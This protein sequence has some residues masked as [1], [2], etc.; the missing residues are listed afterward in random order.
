MGIERPRVALLSNGEE[1]TKGTP[2]LLE[3]HRQ[4]AERPV[5]GVEFVG[6]VE[7]TTLTEG[8]ADVVVADG[9]TGN[10]ALKLMEGVSST[11]FGAVRRAAESSVRGRAGGLLLR[12]ALRGLRDELDPE[13]AG[14]AYILGLR[15]VGVVHH[16][17]FTRHG[18]ARAI[19]VAERGVRERAVERTQEALEAAGALRGAPS[20]SAASVSGR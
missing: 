9:F 3:A 8:V 2:E 19:G 15:R 10:V 20:E 12:G 4:L 17:R 11:L 1:A 18:I 5:A 7:G 16:G 13:A 6:N 14:G